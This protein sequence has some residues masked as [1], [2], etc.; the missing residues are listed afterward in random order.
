MKKHI[1]PPATAEQLLQTVGATKEDI[2]IVDR[3]LRELGYDRPLSAEDDD[4]ELISWDAAPDSSPP[5]YPYHTK[6]QD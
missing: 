4:E 5:S 1:A 6:K 2:E 3:V